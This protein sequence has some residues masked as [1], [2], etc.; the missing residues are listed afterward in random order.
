MICGANSTMTGSWLIT[1]TTNGLEGPIPVRTV[2]VACVP[3]LAYPPSSTIPT[4][5]TMLP[6]LTMGL[7]KLR[8]QVP[9]QELV[10]TVNLVIGANVYKLA[11]R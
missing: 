1:T 5:S 8:R 11:G 2:V 4:P 6:I 10:N 9:M 3:T 7:L